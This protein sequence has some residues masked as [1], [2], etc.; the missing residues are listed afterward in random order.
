MCEH[1]FEAPYIK[2]C[3]STVELEYTVVPSVF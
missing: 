1:V 3:Y 2:S